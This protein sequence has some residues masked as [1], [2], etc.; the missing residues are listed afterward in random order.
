MGR[1]EVPELIISECR[2]Y[3]GHG[4]VFYRTDGLAFEE[5]RAAKRDAYLREH[6]E[7]R[8]E[9]RDL[10][11]K[12]G[13][14][15]GMLRDELI[16]AWGLIQEDL[17]NL[18]GRKTADEHDYYARWR[19]FNV[20]RPYEVFLIHNTV[21]GVREDPQGAFYKEKPFEP[22]EP[23]PMRRPETEPPEELRKTD[24]ALADAYFGYWA[25]YFT[26]DGRLFGTPH[27]YETLHLYP[28]DDG[29]LWYEIEYFTS[30][31][32]VFEQVE[33]RIEEWGGAERYHAALRAKGRER[34][35]ATLEERARAAL[36][37]ADELRRDRGEGR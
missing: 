11:E 15:P 28:G 1:H 8:P 13:V 27:D 26:N 2:Q 20:G 30:L 6:P 33:R 5:R 37:I 7:T 9:Y 34:D 14:T 4:Q 10:I 22:P 35:T 25:H 19:G 18:V 36:D 21:V 24:A 3:Y 29:H 12:A 23:P 32:D 17:S 31:P 16:A